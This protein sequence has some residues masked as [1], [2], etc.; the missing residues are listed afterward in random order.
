MVQEIAEA[1]EKQ[2]V[3]GEEEEEAM[4][5]KVTVV[6]VTEVLGRKTIKNANFVGEFSLTLLLQNIFKYNRANLL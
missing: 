6:L 3:V 4:V 2:V 5:I 1:I